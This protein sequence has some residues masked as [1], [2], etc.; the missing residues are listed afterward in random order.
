MQPRTPAI[1]YRTQDHW[2]DAERENVE[3]VAE[4]VRLLMIDHDFDAVRSRFGN[5]SY[6]QHSRGIPDGIEGLIDY[7]ATLAGRFPEYAYDVKSVL[8]DGD[9]ITFQSHATIRAKHRGD[10]GKGFNIIDTWRVVDGQIV[11]HW[12]A[13]QPLGLSM[14]LLALLVGG[15]TRNP[16]SIF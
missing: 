1:E 6:V 8:A 5:A 12:D 13:I 15:R 7:V 14:R 9:H 2:T 11:E 16:N 10:E 3:A 4:F